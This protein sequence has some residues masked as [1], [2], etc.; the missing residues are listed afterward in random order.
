MSTKLAKELARVISGTG[1]RET[2]AYDATA[3]VVR[4]EGNIAWVHIPGGVD[5]TPVS[6]TLNAAVG[7]TV[8]VRVSGGRAWITGNSSNPPTDDTTANVAKIVARQAQSTVIDM[9][10]RLDSGEFDGEDATILRIDSSRGIVFKN[11]RFDTVLSVV[12]I[13]GSLTITDFAA[14]RTHFGSGAY[15]QWM[16]RGPDDEDFKIMSASDSRI[17]D[18]GFKMT[19]TPSDVD[20]Q[21]VFYCDLII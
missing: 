20:R 17:S 19:I 9:Q 1:K 13:T 2:S 11:D 18:N 16:C 6:R 8:Q 14:L 15:L 21:I 7:D 12:I 4:V 5:E 3:T 10:A